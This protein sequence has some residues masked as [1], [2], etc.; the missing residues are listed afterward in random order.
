MSVSNLR[1]VLVEV[2]G[3]LPSD[4][5]IQRAVEKTGITFLDKKVPYCFKR[6]VRFLLAMSDEEDAVPDAVL[7]R[8]L[9]IVAEKLL[10][11]V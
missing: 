8:N 4:E 6:W 10:S 1:M 9:K 7:A 5:Q 2:L 3:Y 11:A